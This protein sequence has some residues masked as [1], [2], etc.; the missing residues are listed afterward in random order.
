ML[1]TYLNESR[2][3]SKMRYIKI[4]EGFVDLKKD[5]PSLGDFFVEINDDGAMNREVGVD[6]RNVPIHK[7]PSKDFHLG[8]YGVFDLNRIDLP[9]DTDNDISKEFFEQCWNS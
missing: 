4:D 3:Q 7:Y 1:T 8:R 2:P 6:K 5:F 9:P